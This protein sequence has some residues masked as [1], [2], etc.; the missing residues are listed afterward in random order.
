MPEAID[1]LRESGIDISGHVARRLDPSLIR[2]ADLVLAMAGEHRDAVVRHAPEARGRTFTL[3]E[4]VHLLDHLPDGM[5]PSSADTGDRL[6]EAV[7]AAAR[8]GPRGGSI[9]HATRTSPTRSASASRHSA[10]ARGRS[11]S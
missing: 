4:F 8:C 10:P 7:V 1:A 6:H 11:A 2:G 5:G 9:R 3:K